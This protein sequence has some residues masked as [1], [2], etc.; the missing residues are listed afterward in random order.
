MRKFSIAFGFII[1]L[2]A[3][4]AL[5]ILWPSKP[6]PTTTT[7][8]QPTKP[9]QTTP[10]KTSQYTPIQL[11]YNYQA[12]DHLTYKVNYFS[13]G[14]I[15]KK[16]K[17]APEAINE[18]MFRMKISG[19]LHQRI[20]EIKD[21]KIFAGYTLQASLIDISA[22]DNRLK[23]E[24]YKAL[25]TEIFVWFQNQ[26]AIERWF[27]PTEIPADLRNTMKSLLLNIQ[28]QFA[29]TANKEW[30][31]E[32]VDMNGPY[33]AKYSCGFTENADRLII[34]KNKTFYVPQEGEISPVIKNSKGTVQWDT[35]TQ[36]IQKLDWAESLEINALDFNTLGT[37]QITIQLENK[38]NDPN[39][40]CSMDKKITKGK[41]YETKSHKV[42]GEEIM[43]R[44]RLERLIAGRTWDD[45][46]K[47][48]DQ[49]K[50]DPKNAKQRN[51]CYR[52]LG[53]WMELH[54]ENIAEIT[55]QVIAAQE[56]DGLTST[57]LSALSD[58]ENPLAQTAFKEILDKRQDDPNM[59]AATLSHMVLISNPTD[60]SLELVQNL[61]RTNNN[62][63]V[64]NSSALALGGMI[65]EIR[66]KDPAK[67][68]A[69]IYDMEQ[70]LRGAQNFDQKKIYLETLG[71]AGSS[72]SLQTISPFLSD[73]DE[74]IQASAVASLRFIDSPEAD[75]LL[76]QTFEKNTSFQVRNSVI[77]TLIYRKPTQAIFAVLQKDIDK[78]S[79]ENLRLKRARALWD[80]RRQFPLAETTVRNMIANDPSSKVRSSLIQATLVDRDQ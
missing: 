35:Q 8:S 28:V 13:S 68:N 45:L 74:N 6:L 44:R 14:K 72:S 53:A 2:L 52:F 78:E 24:M 64:K 62:A 17:T 33:Q 15:I 39:L 79:S 71:N 5:T 49:V 20:Y 11:R 70:N 51:E 56:M 59:V 26:G 80:M 42:E 77:D 46:K 16:D 3:I 7:N 12:G 4:I 55:K 25:E 75:L 66:K 23:R 47:A 40:A 41:V 73:S 18:E 61:H 76:A 58:V 57:I 9:T 54:P 34:L 37:Y 32:E 67:A 30:Q 43:K 63:Q 10:E 29:E 19:K 27:F 1:I 48:M 50:Q 21:K 31:V 60:E 65:G 69:L 38:E 22:D 36:V